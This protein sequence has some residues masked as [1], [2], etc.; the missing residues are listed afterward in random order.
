MNKLIE[1]LVI[2]SDQKVLAEILRLT[3]ATPE[4]WAGMYNPADWE[5]D[6]ERMSAAVNQI[7]DRF[8]DERIKGW[9]H[10][11]TGVQH[12]PASPADVDARWKAAEPQFRKV[13]GKFDPKVQQRLRIWRQKKAGAAANCPHCH[14]PMA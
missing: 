9:Q 4:Q 14:R 13:L 12:P 7:G 1:A 3:E 10:P 6:P 8:K 11:E 5:P 2:D